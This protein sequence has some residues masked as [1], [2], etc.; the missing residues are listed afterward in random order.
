MI[1]L[2]RKDRAVTLNFGYLR[3]IRGFG[4]RLGC[5]CGNVVFMWKKDTFSRNGL[6]EVATAIRG[7]VGV[8]AG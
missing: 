3:H 1:A 8:R 4:P 2:E 7:V 6:Q 5:S